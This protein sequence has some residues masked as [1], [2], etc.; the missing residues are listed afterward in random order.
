MCGLFVSVNFA[1]DRPAIDDATAVGLRD[2]LA[3]RG[4]D[5]AGLWRAGPAV[6]AH[7]RLA[8]VDLTDAGAQPMV[9][10]DGAV[11][12]VYNGELYNDADL[13][14]Q[15]RR[16]DPRPFASDC[17]TET[18]LRA[19]EV[20]GEDALARFR[21]M[22]ALAWWD[23]R[24]RRLTLARD[25][26]GVKPLYYTEVG[27]EVVAASEPGP[28]LHH[29][30]LSPAPNLAMLS[31]YL[32]T[33][34]TVLGEDTLF[35]GVLAVEPGSLVRFEEARGRVSRT[36]RWHW[37]PA[38]AD[39]VDEGAEARTR[40]VVGES[41]E[42]HL[43]ADAPLCAL[44]SGGL[45]STILTALARE[46]LDGLRTYA[47]GAPG[48]SEND[49]LACAAAVASELG[50]AHE[51]AIVDRE[52][53]VQSWPEMVRAMGVPLSTPNETAIFAVASRLRADGC[54]VTISGEGADELFAGY[55]APTVAAWRCSRADPE[56]AAGGLFQLEA[57]AWVPLGAKRRVLREAALD[58]AGADAPLVER[59][60]SWFAEAARQAGPF[61]DPVEAHLRLLQRVNL[62]GLLQRLDSA[63]MLAGVE[64]RTPF[65]DAVV[66]HHAQG[67]PIS[68]K[69]DPGEAAGAP[70]DAGGGVA[71]AAEVRTKIALR[72]AF[73]GRIPALALDRPKAS[74]PLPFR[75][76]LADQS[77]ALR[78]S[79]FAREV[80]TPEA[81]DAV[82]AAPGEH[83]RLAWPMINAALWGDVWWS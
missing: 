44:L 15:I 26:L 80:F 7:R 12:L 69:F 54:V 21:G 60:Q 16:L 39:E 79:R 62:T 81:I 32:T 27:G 17:D 72:R 40:E 29:P 24:R 31:A 33:I 55:A 73:R 36:V 34:R 47:A 71:V 18:V 77:P 4:P 58:A 46:R 43:R 14:A 50:V 41:L 51:R 74:F 78:R 76:W 63:T 67:L 68:M 75:E 82:S 9:S 6:L 25:P 10:A 83:W 37:T 59:Y 61:A 66:A 56:G 5:G 22:Y 48:G 11:A 23:A 8:V 49:D 19:I 38:P 3:H 13:R 2:R 52:A 42:A 64:G 45:D 53:F 30:R 70:G 1:G 57:N 28:I 20:F 35:Q 65:A